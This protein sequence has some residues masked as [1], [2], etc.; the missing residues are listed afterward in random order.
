MGFFLLSLL[1]FLQVVG[2]VVVVGLVQL[3]FEVVVKVVGLVKM[4]GWNVGG[5][6]V[7]HNM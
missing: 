5:G 1:V 4:V 2:V 3:V 6:K 7:C